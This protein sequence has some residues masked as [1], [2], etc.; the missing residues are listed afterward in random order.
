MLAALDLVATFLQH[1]QQF[2]QRSGV[3][4]QDE[5]YVVTDLVAYARRM[6]VI[7]SPRSAGRWQRMDNGQAV[8]QTDMIADPADGV[9]CHEEILELA[10]AVERCR[11]VDDVI[12]DVRAVG[13]RADEEC[14][15]ALG[16][17]HGE[18]VADP[19]SLLRRDLARL[20]GLTDLIGDDIAV[21]LAVPSCIDSLGQF[22]FSRRR[23]RIALV[24]GDELPVLCLVRILRIVD[25]VREAL[26]DGLAPLLVE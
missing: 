21:S 15:A 2:V 8:F 23:T 18:F 22:E 14:V 7:C 24:G 5:I 19:V 6:R 25:P 10:L 4:L 1:P 3:L 13:M 16:E 26:Q 11:I 9:G 17:P 12:V 20:E